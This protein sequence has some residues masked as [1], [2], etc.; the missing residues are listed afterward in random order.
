ME[1]FRLSEPYS[2]SKNSFFIELAKTLPPP[3]E[4]KKLT[5]E[6]IIAMQPASSQRLMKMSDEEHAAFHA[7]DIDPNQAYVNKEA[8]DRLLAGDESA[9]DEV[10]GRRDMSPDEVINYERHRK[11][12][13]NT[14][15]QFEAGIGNLKST[16]N[17]SAPPEAKEKAISAFIY[18]PPAPP[19]RIN[20]K[21]IVGLAPVK[22]E[23]PI[24]PPQKLPRWW[25]RLFGE[26]DKAEGHVPIFWEKK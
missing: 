23:V 20:P 24:A 3:K 14:Q 12:S 16:G 7:S 9:Y 13:K 15:H 11:T 8:V 26:R 4:F 2:A 6:E 25:Q 19:E 21:D 10:I 22:S 17:T 1:K 18:S 5:K